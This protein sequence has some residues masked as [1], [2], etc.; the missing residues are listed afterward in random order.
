L[1]CLALTWGN[2]HVYLDTLVLIGSVATGLDGSRFQF[3]AG[4]VLASF[5]FFFSLG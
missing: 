4:A 5:I 1:I 2:P 3:G